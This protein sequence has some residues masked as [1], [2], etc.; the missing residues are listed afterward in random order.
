VTEGAPGEGALERTLSG[1]RALVLDVD[2]TIVDTR[3]AMLAAGTHAARALWPELLDA[4]EAMSRHY[5]TDPGRQFRR[6]AAGERSLLAMRLAR[7]GDVAQSFGVAVP[8]DALDI[9]DLAY[10]PAFRAAQR[11]FEDVP[12]LLDVAHA[13]GF[14]VALLTNSSDR[15]TRIKLDVL[16]LTERLD[17]IVTTDTIG[18]GKPDPRVYAAACSLV[19]AELGQAVC[20]GDSLEWD[21]HGAMA[22]GMRAIWL[23]RAGVGAVEVPT[24]ISLTEVT[25][26]LRRFGSPARGG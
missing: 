23:D 11:L 5:Y 15:D 20:I 8:E 10:T 2:D 24:V 25:D 26:A 12:D 19:G 13:H 17:L 21:V 16:G 7:I 3:E 9:F 1:I 18:V 14:P 4:H 22:A 6:Y